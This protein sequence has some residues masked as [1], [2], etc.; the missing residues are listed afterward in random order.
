MR[1]LIEPRKRRSSEDLIWKGVLEAFAKR[2]DI[3]FAYPTQRIYYNLQEGK[4]GTV[5]EPNFPGS[6][7]HL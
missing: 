5:K 2:K 6:L 4:E 1:Y 3:D 7:G